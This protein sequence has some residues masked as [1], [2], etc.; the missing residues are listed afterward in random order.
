MTALSHDRSG[1]AIVAD[2]RP[3]GAASDLG[4]EVTVRELT[5]LSEH[6]AVV[7]LLGE[8][9]G[10]STNPPVTTEMLRA[11]TKAGH[12]VSGAFVG[13]RLVGATIGF[14]SAPGRRILHS[15][16]AGVAPDRTGLG[17]GTAMK[18]HQRAWALERELDAIEWTFDPLVSR[19]A[20]FNI[21]KL[22]AL[23]TEYL[24][25][26]YGVMDDGINGADQTDRLLVRWE[27]GARAAPAG[28]A[29]AGAALPDRAALR[30]V[31][32]PDDIERLRRDDPD[33]ARAW[34]QRVRDELGGLM[35]A[36]GRVVGFER[37]R[38]YLVHI[39]EG[40]P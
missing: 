5:E 33:G 32:V 7:D 9:W 14:A 22:G 24:V 18:L 37:G 28:A 21:C 34:R 15:H 31:A 30:A 4:D 19:N 13:S 23:P 12:Y 17:I 6:V 20:Y 40:T 2:E 38:G 29:P 3:G 35:R 25:D 27:L 8:I 11:L 1:S 16:I 39:E 10:R 26:F 36:D